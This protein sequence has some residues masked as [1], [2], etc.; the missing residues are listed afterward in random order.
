MFSFLTLKKPDTE[1]TFPA[2]LP[3]PEYTGPDLKPQVQQPFFQFFRDRDRLAYLPI[4]VK[5]F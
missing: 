5:C 1:I 3:V 2:K 4:I